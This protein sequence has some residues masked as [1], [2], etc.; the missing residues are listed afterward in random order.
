MLVL[1]N[2]GSKNVKILD[3]AAQAGVTLLGPPV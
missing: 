1:K 2:S 3:A